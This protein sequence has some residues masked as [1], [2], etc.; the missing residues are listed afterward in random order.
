MKTLRVYTD[1][2]VVGGII[3]GNG[4]AAAIILEDER[5]R[6]ASRGY[7]ATSNI[8]MELMAVILALETLTE[9]CIIR[10]F[11]DYTGLV[12]V[13][14]ADRH[15]WVRNAKKQKH[16]RDLWDRIT[17]LLNSGGHVMD[18]HWVKG[19]SGDEYNSLADYEAQEAALDPTFYDVGFQDILAERGKV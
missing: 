5:I 9:P 12:K 17:Y 18:A 7:H 11:S 2:S 8:R 10:L 16:N 4:G 15:E 14:N 13:L 3:G 6:V 19:H 1:G